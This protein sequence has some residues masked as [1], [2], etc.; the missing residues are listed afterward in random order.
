MNKEANT[1]GN[2]ITF[3]MLQLALDQALCLVQRVHLSQQS[4]HKCL[5]WAAEFLQRASRGAELDNQTGCML[6][7][8]ELSAQEKNFT[9]GLEELSTWEPLLV[10]IVD[11]D[12]MNKLREEV[13][14]MRLRS[15]EI[16]RQLEAY[17][18]VQKRCVL[19]KQMS[20]FLLSYINDEGLDHA[21]FNIHTL[22]YFV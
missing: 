16:K 11:T 17:R 13:E 2:S 3:C 8:E 20:I 18:E 9:A 1:E 10:D 22:I 14:S 6:D 15:T 7:L 21:Y 5:D 4:M 19:C 12:V